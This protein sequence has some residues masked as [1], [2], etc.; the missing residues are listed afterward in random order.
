[1]LDIQEDPQA[2]IPSRW[3]I[4]IFM[5]NGKANHVGLSIPNYG[6]ADLSLHG[7]RIIS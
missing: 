6:L 7:A 2:D 5:V 3:H 4:V 1:M